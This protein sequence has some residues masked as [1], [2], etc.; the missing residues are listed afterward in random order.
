[1]RKIIVFFGLMLV[2]LSLSSFN[3]RLDHKHYYSLFENQEGFVV[4]ATYDGKKD[5]GYSFLSKGKDGEHYTLTFQ[6]ADN[7]VLG[8]Y[9]LNSDA[10]IGTKFKITFNR[11]AET[12]EGEINTITKLE[13]I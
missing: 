13:K 11:T 7:A 1:M 6:K 12:S 8:S 3:L 4:Y 9:D 10:L 5:N 2:M